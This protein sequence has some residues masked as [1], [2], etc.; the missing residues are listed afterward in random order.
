MEVTAPRALV[1]HGGS[2]NLPPVAPP[3]PSW[4]QSRRPLWAGAAVAAGAVAVFLLLLWPQPQTPPT[5]SEVPAQLPASDGLTNVAPEEDASG[6]RLPSHALAAAV[7]D[8]IDELPPRIAGIIR[9]NL[10]P[11]T[12]NYWYDQE[13]GLERAI[14]IDD[15]G[16]SLD[17][18]GKGEYVYV[19]L[20]EDGTRFVVR[21]H[22]TDVLEVNSDK[23]IIAHQ[24]STIDIRGAIKAGGSTG[25]AD[26]VLTAQGDGQPPVWKDTGDL[27]PGTPTAGNLLVADGDSWESVAMSGDVT[28]N[29]GGVVSIGDD[30]ITEADLKTVD[31]AA[32]EECLTFETTTGDFEWQSCGSGGGGSMTS[33]TLSDGTNTQTIADGNTLLVAAGSDIDTTVSATDTVTIALESTIDSV[34][35]INLA[36]TGTLNGLDAI[37]ATTETTL[38]GA[39]DIAGEVTGTGLGSVAISCTDCLNAT[40]I[41][42]I[43]VFNTGDTITGAVTI[44][45]SADAIQLVVQGNATQTSNLLTLEQSDGTDVLTVT[46]AGALTANST[47]STPTVTLTG[48]GTL[49]GL[50]AVDATGEDTIEALIF[51]AD[52][53]NI[54]GVWEVQD[55]VDFVFGTDANWAIQYDEAVDDQLLFVTTGTAATAT[56]DPLFEILV[57]ATPTADQQVFGV[58]KGSQASNT[59]LFTVDE[60]GDTVMAGD[61]T[62]TGDDLF[63]TTNTSGHILVADGTN[64]NPV[65]MSGDITIDST[66]ATAIGADKVTEADLKAV[67]T[68]ADEECLTFESTAGDF[69]WQTCSPSSGGITSFNVAGDTGT[70]QTI[71][72]ANT[73]TIATGAALTAT[74][75]ATDT[76]TITVDDDGLDFAQFEDTMDLDAALVLNQGTNTWTQSFTGTTTTGYTYNATSLTS[77]SALDI[78]VTNTH[79]ADAAIEQISVDLTNAQATLAN[80]D[81][82][83][84]SIDFTNNPTVAGNT[85]S[86][87]RIRAAVTA[88]TT[89]NAI[90]SLLI[91]DNADTS[92]AGSTV[93]TDALR[94]INSG[95]IAGGI[96]NAINIDDTDVTTDIVLQNDE[97]ID[98]NT[99]GTINLTATTLQLTGTTFTGNGA[100]TYDAGGAAAIVIGSADVTSITLTTDGTGTAEVVLPAGAIGSTEIL[101]GDILEADLKVVDTPADEE[102]LTFE[103]TGGD[104]EWQS[105]STGSMTSF[106]ISDGTNTQAI[107][108]GNTLLVA[109]GAGI[110]TTVSATD[111][112]TIAAT[113]GTS[114][115]GSEVDANTL[116]YV[117]FEDTMD[118]DAALTL[119]QGTNTWTQSFTGTTTDGYTYSAT[120]LT[121]GTGLDFNVTNT[122]TADAAIEQVQFDLTNAQA[123]LANSNFAGLTVNFTNNPSIAANTETAMRIQNQVTAN[124]TDNAVASLL[125]L[126]NADTSAAG[127]TVVTD[128]LRIINSGN[129][130]GGITNAINIDDTDVT[131]D[132]VLQNDETI[133]NNTDGTITLTAGTVTTSSNATVTGDL[134]ITG[135]DL[136]MTTNTSGAVL[137]ADGTNFNP[138]VMSG[139]VAIGTT[140]TT[141]IQANAVALTTDTTGD[142][143]A[144]IVA[145]SGIATTGAAT[146]EGIA[147]SISVSGVGPSN[148]TDDSLDFVDFED[149]MDL[150]AATE[151]NLAGFD[152][153]FDLDGT[154]DFIIKDLG[155]AIAT[156]DDAGNITF[157]PTD[158]SDFLLNLAAG[159]NTQFAATAA[160]TVDLVTISNS[161][162]GTVTNGVD[163]LAITSEIASDAAT[164]TNSALNIAATA[165]GDSGDTLRGINVAMIS[166]A[167]G[168]VYGVNIAGITAGAATENGLVIGSG[169][170]TGLDLATNTISTGKGIN[171]TST[172]STITAGELGN[173]AL[174]TSAAAP[175]NKTGNL[176]SITSTRTKSGTTGTTADDYDLQSLLRESATTGVGGTLT[177]TGSVLRIENNARATG[178]TL[179]DTVR[180]I[181]LVME[182]GSGDAIFIDSN[183]TG[184]TS[185]VA[186]N[187]DSEST[188]ADVVAIDGTRLTTGDALQLSVDTDVLSTGKALRIR[189]TAT[190]TTDVLTVD[191][192]GNTV[193]A[194]DLTITGDDLFMTTN[195]SGFIL[196]ADGTNY[197][198]VAVSGDVTISSAGAV[199]IGA[200]KILES[201]LKAV[202]AASDEECLTFETTTGDF[203]WQS[204]GGAATTTLQQAYDNDVDGGNA[205]I[206]LTTADDSIVISN[207]AAS[208]TDSAFALQIDQNATGVIALDIDA[209]NT[210]ADIINIS[211][212]PLTT[213]IAVDIPDLNA[214]TTG[215]GLN[216]AST[217]SAITS[218]EL[219]TGT[220]TASSPSLANKTGS[221]FSMASSRTR[222]GTSGTTADDYD[223]ASFTRTSIVSGIGTTLTAAG[224]VLRLENIA[225]QSSGTL[226]DTVNVLEIVQDTVSTGAAIRV[227]NLG[228]G[229]DLHLVN[230]NAGTDGVT[231]LFHHDS[232]SPAAADTVGSLNFSG[233]DMFSNITAYAEIKTI[234][235]V[236]TDTSE[237]GELVFSTMLNGTLTEA[238]RVDDK[239][240]VG[241]GTTNPTS[242]LHVVND[243]ANDYVGHFFHDG[244]AANRGGIIIQN[245]TD[246]NSGTNFHIVFRDGDSTE[247]GTITS[248]T[249]TVSYNAFTGSHYARTSETLSAGTL[250]TLTG[251]NQPLYP[252]QASEI[253]YGVA[254]SGTA[255]DARI[256]G[257]YLTAGG[258]AAHPEVHLVAAVGNGDLWVVD[259][260]HNL[261][262]G[263]N[264]ISADVAGHAM[265]DPGTY[266]IAHVTAQAAESVNWST[267]TDSINGRKRKKI[268]VTFAK[269][270]LFHFAENL[271]QPGLAAGD[272]GEVLGL[273][274]EDPLTA[275]TDRVAALEAQ[276]AQD[277]AI[278]SPQPAADSGLAFAGLPFTESP[279]G[280][281]FGRNLVIDGLLTIE[282]DTAIKGSLEVF[283]DATFYAN[284]IAETVHVAKGLNVH[285]DSIL[286]GNL[287]VDGDVSVK[288]TLSLDKTQAGLASIPR[289]G[290]EVV[291]PYAEPYAEAPLVQVTLIK[292]GSGEA[293]PTVQHWISEMAAGQFTIALGALAPEEVTFSWVTL[294]VAAPETIAGEPVDSDNDGIPDIDDT[295]N[296]A[297][298]AEPSPVALPQSS[299]A[300]EDESAVESGDNDDQ[301]A[302]SPQPAAPAAAPA[303]EPSAEAA[304][305][306][307]T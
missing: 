60:D 301:A 32:D 31:A 156:F 115:S 186:I 65:A 131:T 16:L 220:L 164:D 304:P 142:Y 108:D 28:I 147:H 209:E 13:P 253:V 305:E 23:D 39:L 128:A 152:Y 191:G 283:E 33:F 287:T 157:D 64:Y 272:D 216:L 173:F 194:G 59:A 109:A 242:R 11:N 201:H 119:N 73:L 236:V 55:D 121:S 61:L 66:G 86:A 80:S 110:T 96:V 264:L 67:D 167:A 148:I 100:T 234:S 82:V 18:Y 177:A 217:S 276:A 53:E 45:G 206:A 57:G 199:T 9:Q 183:G 202:D 265:K 104:F 195:T 5:I 135:D 87:A 36:G 17:V 77:G 165:S 255:N 291:V 295:D 27:L 112:V 68:P 299:P 262:P 166:A 8:A 146:G 137:V 205:T 139:D 54:S 95:N 169:W 285:G 260:G 123:T 69:E 281:T 159:S 120:S 208:G 92:T 187:I 192:A 76:V 75:G 138:V 81:F 233:E 168:T 273:S 145:G 124:T 88:N 26:Q 303:A 89:D 294:P 49:N 244:N 111:T 189:G 91:L 101:D 258:S 20:R 10:L 162:F 196:V 21:D 52:A 251:D 51:D 227:T 44:D 102:C 254:S 268:S 292:Q 12:L 158:G 223:V 40:E 93:V 97:T 203:E 239:G 114:V 240:Y 34:A 178:G 172:S 118:L 47:I 231:V 207:P 245:G 179:T 150:D 25:D 133:D 190:G 7:A 38:E 267:V 288:G 160:P 225:T 63:M 134:T 230:T 298:T 228:T 271:D 282:S 105:C 252:D 103:A 297:P 94:I 293:A 266:A 174:N 71:T 122:H 140:G 163:G 226:T 279:E 250:V 259:N 269:Y 106:T 129:I 181:E 197:N 300:Q 85:E 22:E 79:T 306:P 90:A 184:T 188:T 218:G 175:S 30:K 215:K 78:N 214:L 24:G 224:S 99:D 185:Q 235:T 37:D 289:G 213:G 154:G 263:D 125:T 58:A 237:D 275:L 127:S 107:T 200:D 14:A 277:Q 2:G 256:L 286:L 296:A 72:D 212:A 249:G 116:D 198:P 261:Q 241:V 84:Y 149:I 222:S 248:T 41:E 280:F 113:L 3:R 284:L 270:D 43:Y 56:T 246:D 1:M 35:T 211:A 238:M 42:D 130:A 50:D 243:A 170:D 98:N 278:A 29:S 143:V 132:I 4:K 171:V 153:S 83:G 15:K 210:T 257:A 19:D 182:G 219:L 229:N 161:G 247:V 117:D 62:I 74:A 70:P 48:T 232:A 176:F 274:S 136:F 6:R 141:T 180:G 46:N 307:S 221:L 302:A 144:T 193:M 155:T 151:V 290:R 204:C 126:D